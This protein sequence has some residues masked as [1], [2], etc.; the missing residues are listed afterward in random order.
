MPSANIIHNSLLLNIASSTQTLE[1]IAFPKR[2]REN[3][4][5]RILR[6]LR[7]AIESSVFK[8]PREE[9]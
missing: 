7:Q 5:K 1:N 3:L 6:D 2:L 9:Y 8:D 4:R